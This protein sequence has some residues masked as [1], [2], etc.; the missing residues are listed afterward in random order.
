MPRKS[1]YRWEDK[2]NPPVLE[3]HSQVK[4]DVIKFYLERYISVLCSDP[5]HDCL[6]IN[7]ID[8][9]AGGGRYISELDGCVVDGSPLLLVKTIREAE[10]LI[11]RQRTKPFRIHDRYYFVEKNRQAFQCLHAVLKENGINT[12]NQKYQLFNKDFTK[13]LPVILSN[14]HTRSN[15]AR[16][17]FLLDQYGY[18]DVPLST[19]NLIFAT[20]PSTAEVI[21]TF[22]T[23]TIINYLSTN[24]NFMTA[25][26][27]VGLD[28]IFSCDKVK[29]FRES[30]KS[31]LV[32]EQELF[33]EI[34]L[35]SGA[36]YFTPFFIK[37]R[38]SSRSYWLIHL[39]GHPR[40][41]NEM[42]EIHWQ[43]SN[44]FVHHGRAGLDGIGGL[45]M[46]LG[47]EPKLNDF[48]DQDA[49]EFVFDDDASARTRDALFEDIPALLSYDEPLTLSKL[50]S[51]TCNGTPANVEHYKQSIFDLYSCGAIQILSPNGDKLKRPRGP[52]GISDDSV[53]LLSKQAGLF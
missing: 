23:D 43:H 14:I 22:S 4:H 15:R 9:F 31:R 28:D 5:R 17:L 13:I 42:C 49:F 30:P 1:G 27:R 51:E 41:R 36:R 52:S 50:F 26:S 8:G 40:A 35:K 37:A 38:K 3:E 25:M 29:K 48:V 33:K 19:L 12:D 10:S 16:C 20:F 32:I 6:R 34:C 21:L 46:I 7:L 45:E 2:N 47:Y 24:D 18:K 53:I 44:N 11:K 39:S